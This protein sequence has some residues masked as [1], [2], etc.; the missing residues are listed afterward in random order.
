[1]DVVQH[2]AQSADGEMIPY[3][4]VTPP[5][6]EADGSDPTLLT[7]YGGFEIARTPYYSGVTGSAWLEQG[8][9]LVLANIRGGGEFGPRWHHAALK[10]NRQRAYDDQIGRAS[11]RERG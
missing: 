11:C 7:A 2:E 8:G 1:M 3:F 9:V 5:N 10:E 6:F 4:L